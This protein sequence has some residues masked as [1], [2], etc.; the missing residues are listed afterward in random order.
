[1]GTNGFRLYLRLGD[2]VSHR[3][4]GEWGEGTVVEEMTSTIPGGT[5]LVRI[6]F[7]DGRQR[8]FN[9]DLDADVCCYYF[10]LQKYWAADEV[11]GAPTRTRRRVRRPQPLAL[12]AA[13][14]GRRSRRDQ[15]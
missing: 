3:D 2:T 7:Q 6:K 1:M 13:S 14:A 4:H 5:C 12:P 15:T 10:G 11:L 9:N 8:T